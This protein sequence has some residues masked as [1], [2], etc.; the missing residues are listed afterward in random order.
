MMFSLLN[1][2]M[3]KNK[4]SVVVFGDSGEETRPRGRPGERQLARADRTS[5]NGTPHLLLLLSLQRPSQCQ[6]LGSILSSPTVW[7]LIKSTGVHIVMNTWHGNFLLHQHKQKKKKNT[8]ANSILWFR[9]RIFHL[10]GRTSCCSYFDYSFINVLQS[11]KEW[12]LFVYQTW[13]LLSRERCDLI[14]AWQKI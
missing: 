5:A 9:R 2:E 7:H 11:I 13:L 10:E 6:P 14:E 3:F 1:K 4:L 12:I 8:L